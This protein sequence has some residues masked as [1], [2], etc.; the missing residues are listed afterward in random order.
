MET[1]KKLYFDIDQTQ[2]TNEKIQI[3]KEYFE[4]SSPDD[5]AWAL[6]FLMGRRLKRLISSHDL[7]KWCIDWLQIPDWLYQ[8]CHSA[9]GDT[10][11]TVALLI[12]PS[13]D[14]KPLPALGELMKLH[15]IPLQSQSEEV[16]KQ[17]VLNFWKQLDRKN[18]F[19]FNKLLTGG[20]RV[21]A[22]RQV[23]LKALSLALEVPQEKL[24]QAVNTNTIPSG[25]FFENLRHLKDAEISASHPFPFYLASP[26]DKELHLLGS[27][28]QWMAEWK[29]D[30]IRAQLIMHEESVLLWSRGNEIITEQCPEI[31]QE[32]KNWKISAILDGEILAFQHEKPLPFFALQK[33][34]GRKKPS[35]K[36]QEEIPLI[37][38]AYDLLSQEGLDCRQDP[39]EIRR[40]KLKRLIAHI[41]SPYLLLSP[42]VPFKSWEELKHLQLN[43]KNL[44]AEGL[45]LKDRQSVYR[46]GRTKGEWWKFKL[47]PMTIDAV[48]LYAQPGSGRRANLYTD[49]TFAV[50]QEGQ[51]IPIAKAYSGLDQKEIEELDRWIRR[52]TTEK[53][54]PVRQ[55]EPFYVFEIAFENAQPS[56][57]HKSGVALRFPR[58][59]RWRK[60]KTAEQADQLDDVKK[61]IGSS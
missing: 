53:F 6:F 5:A 60:D 30:G 40:E 3:I 48:L 37:F 34:L 46:T 47:A 9:V 17:F 16:K 36:I 19:I 18:C 42:E 23:T 12:T 11:E 52:H 43:A 13:E 50:W 4:K 35:K 7:K 2:S 31:I 57:R 51:L 24:A 20:F 8:E 15:I 39:F 33:R 61:F 10:A 14:P 44:M 59:L 58:I 22:S 21:G 25:E 38:M 54:G 27:P 41:Q 55:L 26:L 32:A 56:N 29:W 45:M 49:Y 1:F 28:Y